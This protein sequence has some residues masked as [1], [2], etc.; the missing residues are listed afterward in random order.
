MS[1]ILSCVSLT[2]FRYKLWVDTCSEIFGGLDICAVKAIH[3]KD[4]RDYITEVGVPQL[5][6][7]ISLNNSTSCARKCHSVKHRGKP[8][9]R[10]MKHLTFVIIKIL[11]PP[12]NASKNC[13]IV[14]CFCN[15]GGSCR[16]LFKPR[17]VWGLDENSTQEGQ[18]PNSN[19][20]THN[21]E[22]DG[23]TIHSPCH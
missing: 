23:L 3:G 12:T 4:G 10:I 18:N 19:L 20:Q 2:P 16:I 15:V 14:N 11:E 8:H 6:L 22:E 17:Q 7:R 9:S 5:M 1:D 13:V 21:C